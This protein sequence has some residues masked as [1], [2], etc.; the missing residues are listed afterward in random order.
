MQNSTMIDFNDEQKSAYSRAAA[1]CSR[2]EKSPGAVRK[3]LIQWGL[4]DEESDQV[5]QRLFNEQFLD[6]ER[7]ATSYV[8]DKFRFNKWGKIKIAYHLKVEQI[9]SE[10]IA[11]ALDEIADVDYEDCAIALITEKL[12]K[13][14]GANA[15][16]IKA[17]IFRFMQS[18]GFEGDLV[19]RLY[20]KL[21]G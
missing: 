21:N 16:D 18:R 7:F 6:E 4:S 19:A 1:L 9:S 5:M 2:A 8:R 20:G 14:K 12:K 10:K 17:K 15:Y 13:T 3:K 11:A